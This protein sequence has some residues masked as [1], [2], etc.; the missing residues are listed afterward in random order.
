MQ[1]LKLAGNRAMSPVSTPTK[2]SASSP[3]APP[4]AATARRPP[5]NDASPAAPLPPSL[6][7][8]RGRRGSRRLGAPCLLSRSLCGPRV[9]HPGPPGMLPGDRG[10]NPHPVL[11]RRRRGRR[12]PLGQ[13]PRPRALHGQ[14]LPGG[15]CLRLELRAPQAARV[16][17]GPGGQGVGPRHLGRRR[18][19]PGD[20]RGRQAEA[21]HPPGAGVRGEGRRGRNSRERDA[22]V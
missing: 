10:K 3:Q 15:R 20:A 8:R 9:G 22:G 6:P 7:P 19:D 21:G 12:I 14:A 5:L 16:Q 13:R 4:T 18:P 2:A 1:F 11:R 17:E